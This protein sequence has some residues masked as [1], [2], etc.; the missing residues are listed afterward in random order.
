[1]QKA[2]RRYAVHPSCADKKGTLDAVKVEVTKLETEVPDMAVYENTRTQYQ[3]GAMASLIARTAFV[4]VNGLTHIRET[5]SAWNDAR[6][7]RNMLSAL[8][9]RELDDIGLARADIDLV[10]KR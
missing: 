1:M 5:V 8:S 6:V 3:A 4:A 9:D 2:H 10:A 7:T